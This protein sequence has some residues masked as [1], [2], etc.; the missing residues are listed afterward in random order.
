MPAESPIGKFAR[1][2]IAIVASAD[3]MAVAANTLVKSIPALARIV[4]LIT[5]I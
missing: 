5:R 3:A 1:K 4:G 2:P